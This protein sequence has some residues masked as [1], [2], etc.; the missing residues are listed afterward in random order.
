M[1]VLGMGRGCR[2]GR[3]GEEGRPGHTNKCETKRA[4]NLAYVLVT[5]VWVTAGQLED[6]IGEGR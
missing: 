1:K 2:W 5:V 6:R 3:G 4:H